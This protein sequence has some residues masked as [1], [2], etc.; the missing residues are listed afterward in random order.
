M[1]HIAHRE[2]V[3]VYRFLILLFTDHT[4]YWTSV[5]YEYT[6]IYIYILIITYD[7]QWNLLNG[8]AS[9]FY[10]ENNDIIV[11]I[12]MRWCWY[13]EQSYYPKLLSLDTI[14]I[15]TR[16][17]M[18]VCILFII[19]SSKGKERKG[20]PLDTIRPRVRAEAN[21]TMVK[22]DETRWSLATVAKKF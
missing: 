1:V 16:I 12:Y 8:H 13:K 17:Y 9:R 3:D 5:Y 4:I 15:C 20:N 14:Y 19:S 6:Y 10:I 7:N 21:E 22:M 11:H 18:Y 2:C